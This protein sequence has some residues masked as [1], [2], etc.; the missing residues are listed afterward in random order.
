MA[1]L[2]WTESE[3]GY[4][5]ET[6]EQAIDSVL[7]QREQ[8]APQS[9][10]VFM[11]QPAQASDQTLTQTLHQDP[12]AADNTLQNGKYILER[13]LGRGRFAIS[14]LAKRSDGERWVIKVLNPQVLAGLN[15]IERDR[16]ETLFWQEAVKLAKCSGTP[17]IAKVEIPFKEGDLICLPVEYLDGNSLADRSE[18][19]L[20]EQNALTYIRQIGKALTV[21]HQQG[22]VHRDIC[23]ANIYLRLRRGQ[24]DAV[25]TNFEL[26]VDSD[27]ELSRTREQ[28]L[29]DGFSPIELYARGQAIGPYTDVYSLA[30]TL[31]ELL[32]GEVPCSAKARQVNGQALLSPQNKN[33][34]IS[35]KTTKMILAGLELKPEKRPQSIQNWLSRLDAEINQPKPLHSSSVDWSK[36]QAIWAAAA[37]IVALLIGGIPLWH[38]PDIQT[39]P[40]QPPVQSPSQP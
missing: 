22:L 25:L 4:G 30:A 11:S 36:W 34:D 8:A 39:S 10:Q 31:Y 20:L 32:T 21:V 15:A 33:P 12:Q 1:L 26:A 9:A 7:A 27:T 14:Y 23:P 13:E 3:M 24:V 37:V 35:G 18:R 17:H 5:L 38:R 16:Q 40:Q 19:Q 29:T 2:T 28:E 6:L